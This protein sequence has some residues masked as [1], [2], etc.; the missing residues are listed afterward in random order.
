MN[1]PL[2]VKNITKYHVYEYVEVQDSEGKKL[3]SF[4]ANDHT[5]NEVKKFVRKLNK[6]FK[7]LTEASNANS[8]YL[9]SLIVDALNAPK[10]TSGRRP[11]QL[12]FRW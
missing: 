2:K 11:N 10:Y 3:L 6:E 9:E 5:R 1:Y 12:T 7:D 8:I 4:A